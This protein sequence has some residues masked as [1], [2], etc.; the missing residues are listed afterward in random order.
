MIPVMSSPID[1]MMKIVRTRC[2]R[3]GRSRSNETPA[4]ALE[5]A[6]ART[7]GAVVRSCS[8]SRSSECDGSTFHMC[9]P[10]PSRTLKKDKVDCASSRS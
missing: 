1:V 2:H 7:E 3:E 4:D 8:M 6:T 5:N 9:S 10:V